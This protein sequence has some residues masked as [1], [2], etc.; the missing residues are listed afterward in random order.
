MRVCVCVCVCGGELGLNIKVNFVKVWV[1]VRLS[2]IKRGTAVAQES[3]QIDASPTHLIYP[4][5]DRN[6]NPNPNPDL[7]PS[8]NQS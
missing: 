2:T 6:P 3:V 5:L 7:H 8:H 1:G 4:D